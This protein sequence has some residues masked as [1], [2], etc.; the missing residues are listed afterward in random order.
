V[1][2]KVTL[3]T[4][5]IVD[6]G[7]LCPGGVPGI[8]GEGIAL[9]IEDSPLLQPLHPIFLTLSYAAGE[10]GPASQSQLALARF[11]PGSGTCIPLETTFQ[12]GTLIAQLNHFS[13]Y[14]VV[15]VALATSAD[16]ARLFPNPYRAATDGYVT[17]DQVPPGSRVRIFTLRGE[18]IL[19]A[20]ANG[21]GNVTWHG[22]NTAGRS[23][24]SGLYIVVVEAGGT[25]KTLKLAV[26][27]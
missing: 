5:S 21:A 20:V 1:D 17:I 25:K 2:T 15:A 6:H 10:L 26:I 14:Q 12:N 23:V 22:D 13:L 7:P 16:S 11:D 19:D 3:S 24:A 27:R 4:Y 9:S 18:R 8:A